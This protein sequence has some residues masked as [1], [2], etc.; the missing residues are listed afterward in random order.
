MKKFLVFIFSI[1]LSSQAFAGTISIQPFISNNDVTI[2]HLETQRTTLSNAING[3]IEG[4][5][6]IK[7]GTLVTQD[8]SNSVSPITRWDEA[9][10]DFTYTGMLPVTDATLTSNISAGTSYVS[11]YRVV[12]GTT[13]HTYSA[14]KDTYVYVNRGGFYNFDPVANGAA[15]PTNYTADNGN[16]L[17]AKVVTGA[18]SIS[19][20]TDLRTTGISLSSG[21]NL[22]PTDYRKEM[23]V[24]QA[25]TTTITVTSGIL[26]IN[27]TK[28]QKNAATTLTI[29][30][31]GDWAGGSSLRATNTTA[32]VGVD[33]SGNIKMHTTS[34]THANYDLSVTVGTKRY[35]AWGSTTYRIIGWF[36]MNGTGSG[37]LDTYGVSNISDGAIK[38]VVS[39]ETGAVAT[40]TTVVPYDDSIPQS[41]EG[42]QYMSLNFV[43]S[44]SNDKLMI[45][46]TGFFSS[47]ATMNLMAVSLFQDSTADALATMAYSEKTDVGSPKPITFSHY[48][49]AGTT[50]LTT[51][52]VRAGQDTAGTTTFNG[53]GGSRFYGG[54]MASSI[55]IEEINSELT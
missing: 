44:N 5:I 33:S 27:G 15:A 2:S 41:G 37:E 7:A 25:S 28:I 11:G 36:R 53:I 46:V 23:Y 47:S 43:P 24:M 55:R 19:S 54:V 40:G 34:P 12:I 30:T 35:A 26:E 16:L 49:K 51:F 3:N 13:A 42:D 32:Y 20:V 45:T 21:A 4:G 1:F 39:Y 6:N 22:V 18:S 8:F 38:N 29:S 9:F 31:A 14:S 10:N 17:L 48:M 52:K 50:S